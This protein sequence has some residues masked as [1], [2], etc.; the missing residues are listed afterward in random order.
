M[1]QPWALGVRLRILGKLHGQ[2]C[3]NVL[4]FATNTQGT[5]A[6]GTDAL[7]LALMTAVLQCITD[8]LLPGVT[9]EY[10]L[11]ALEAT[12]IFPVKGDP[13]VSA[14]PANSVGGRGP[15][16]A[17][18]ISTLVQIRTGLGGRSH[19]GRM[20]LPPAGEADTNVSVLAD[21][22][23]T[24]FQQFVTCV[25]TK[26]AGAAPATDWRL[27]VLSRKGA[28]KDDPKFNANFTEAKT[29]LVNRVAAIM[30]TRKVGRGS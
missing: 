4:H 3:I 5:D 1:P 22:A 18:F 15:T 26:F 9:S 14:A 28:T 25:V 10:T 8:Q 13:M 16:S 27:G 19:R 21:D 2:D 29:L 20:F 11:E 12:Q 17:S 7:I 23:L 6:A 24:Q 30:G